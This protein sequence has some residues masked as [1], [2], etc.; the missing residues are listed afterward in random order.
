MD[1]K[2]FDKYVLPTYGRQAV[3]LNRGS[4][5]VA[6][7]GDGGD[8]VD[9]TSGI[10]CNSLGYVDDGWVAAVTE[11][12]KSIQHTC[13]IYYNEQGGLFAKKICEYTGYKGVFYGNSG[14]EA[15]ECAIKICRKY[16]FDKYGKG[17]GTI[18]TLKDSFHG[19]TVTTLSAT[20]Q[21]S[22][23]NYFFP[24][25][26]GFSYVEANSVE[27]LRSAVTD[28][29]CGIM[30]EYIQ[31]E[32][33][34]RPLTADFVS[35]IFALAE[36][37]DLVTIA[38]EVQTGAG[39]TGR[40]LAGEHYGGTADITTLAKGIGGGLPVGV[41]LAGEKV[42]GVLTPG[43]HGST[44]GGNPVVLAGASYV[45][46]KVTDSDFLR[47]AAQKGQYLRDKIL[48]FKKVKECD[49]L[50]LMLGFS[51]DGITAGEV[52][53]KALEQGVA[54]LSAKDRMRLLPPLNITGDEIDLGLERLKKVLDR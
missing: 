20:G 45:L 38:D 33:G 6:Y 26:E 25:T 46:S 29:V 23:H 32:G 15:N 7:S 2:E 37:H 11:Q 43:T 17:R 50:G 1:I 9:F 52:V 51:L 18:I 8:I 14:A 40:F 42:R 13:N 12:L 22:F 39:R 27:A 47:D 34:V 4:H 19:R 54:V 30:F 31:G 36:K 3:M 28:D 21:D 35:E 41:C 49:G 24:F 53:K 16:S 44:F 48:A 5:S 10:G